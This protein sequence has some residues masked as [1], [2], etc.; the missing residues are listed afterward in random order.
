M[1]KPETLITFGTQ[2]TRR[3]QTNQKAQH[4]KLTPGV[5]PG[6]INLRKIRLRKDEGR[7]WLHCTQG[8]LIPVTL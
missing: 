3:R 5:Y 1:D 4:T 6:A 8:P 2:D 7:S